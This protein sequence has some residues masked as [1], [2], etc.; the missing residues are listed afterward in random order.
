M[1]KRLTAEELQNFLNEN[2]DIRAIDMLIPDTSGVARGKRI[3]IDG[4]NKLYKDGVRL[5]RSTYL[6]DTT[7]QNCADTMD[8]GANDGDPD[9]PCF[10]ISGTLSRVPWAAEGRAQIMASMYD[11]SGVPFFGDP[12]NV[13][14]EVIKHFDDMGL[15]PVVAVELEFYLLANELGPDGRAKLATSAS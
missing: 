1:E 4:A 8:Y 13:L 2:P 5:P 11:D 9:R 3:A 14:K 10:G 6:L 7:G 12:R 15:K